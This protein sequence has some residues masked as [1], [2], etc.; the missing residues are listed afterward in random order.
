MRIQHASSDSD[1]LFE[2]IQSFDLLPPHDPDRYE[3]TDGLDN[4]NCT[5]RMRAD[6]SVGALGVFQNTCGMN[7]EI[8]VATGDL[9]CDLLHRVHSL[10]SNPKDVLES[11]LTSF[12][13]EAGF[14][15]VSPSAG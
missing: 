11:A 1:S 3:T 2:R 14:N 10:G 15:P 13:A 12:L 6:F 9:I 4:P 8:E 5:N 7:E